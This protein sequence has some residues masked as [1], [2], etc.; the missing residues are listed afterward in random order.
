VEAFESGP[1]VW[2]RHHTFTWD[3]R[4][5]SQHEEY[6]IVRLD[7]FEAVVHDT[8]EARFSTEL[9]WWPVGE[10]VK[11]GERLTPRSL[12]QIVESYLRIGA[13]S[14]PPP[15]EVVVD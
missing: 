8:D 12:A 4:R 13:P 15:E 2:L 11:T 3:G 10:L 5:I 6:H 14:P 7:R 1:I 9:R